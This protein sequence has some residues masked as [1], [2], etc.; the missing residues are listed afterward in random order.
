MAA[1]VEVFRQVEHKTEVHPSWSIVA[2]K[3][4]RKSPHNKTCHT[5]STASAKWRQHLASAAEKQQWTCNGNSKQIASISNS[6]HISIR[7]L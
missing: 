7:D 6:Q 3:W 1:Q 2:T 5:H 4:G